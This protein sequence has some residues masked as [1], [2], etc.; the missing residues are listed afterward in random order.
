M[1]SDEVCCW[2]EN[3]YGSCSHPQRFCSQ[4]FVEHRQN[5]TD[6]FGNKVIH[7][8][9]AVQGKVSKLYEQ[10]WSININLQIENINKGDW[11]QCMR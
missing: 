7:E 10:H 3:V 2:I 5:L 9:N 11:I 4:H 1:P 6:L 8:R